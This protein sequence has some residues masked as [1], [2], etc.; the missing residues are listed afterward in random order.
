MSRTGT[1][2]KRREA[3]TVG[4]LCDGTDTLFSHKT[5]NPVNT[6]KLI[7]IVTIS[8]ECTH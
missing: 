7:I 2:R 6:G 1:K 4:L 5:N 8:N 3:E